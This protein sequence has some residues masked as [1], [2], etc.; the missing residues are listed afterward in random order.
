[1]NKFIAIAVLGVFPVTGAAND[2][3][4]DVSVGRSQFK[5]IGDQVWVNHSLPHH[6]EMKD[7]T[8]SVGIVKPLSS[9]LDVRFSFDD[10]G[11]VSSD[12][13]ATQWDRDY[14]PVA[15]VCLS[16]CDN[17]ARFKGNGSVKGFSLSLQPTYRYQ[18]WSFFS[19]FGI[20]HMHVKWNM[21]VYSD[22]QSGQKGKSVWWDCEHCSV[23]TWT[24][25]QKFGLGM[26][27]KNVSLSFSLFRGLDAK[28]KDPVNGMPIFDRAQTLM[29]RVAL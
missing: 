20:T 9:W 16:T 7:L 18:D 3:D 6:L 27:Y 25:G 29:L 10:L 21:Q 26:G 17:L 24:K 2:D 22:E 13:L 4:F 5:Q 11:K 1:M 14:D 28:G 8:Y 23:N 19:E 12:A 15:H